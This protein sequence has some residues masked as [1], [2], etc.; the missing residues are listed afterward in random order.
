MERT[1][2]AA[3]KKNGASTPGK[4]PFLLPL[5]AG[6][7]DDLRVD[8]L[9]QFPRFGL[10][11]RDPAQDSHLRRGE[12]ATVGGTHGLCHV[13]EQGQNARVDLLDRATYPAQSLVAVFYDLSDCHDYLLFVLTERTD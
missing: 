8:Q 2:G 13:V 11:H 6:V 12:S 5:F 10:H 3:S 9:D 4:T 1:S 7:G